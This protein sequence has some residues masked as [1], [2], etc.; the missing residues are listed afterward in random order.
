VGL[1][2][3]R[4]EDP[5]KFKRAELLIV[6]KRQKLSNAHGDRDKLCGFCVRGLAFTPDEK[7]LFVS[8]MKGGGISVFA[9]YTNGKHKYLGTVFGILP[10]PRDLDTS[11]DGKTLFISCNASGFVARVPVKNVLDTLKTDNHPTVERK[12]LDVKVAYVGLGARSLRLSPDER[13]LFVAVNQ[14]SEIVVVSTDDM[15][16]VSRIPVD[17]YPVGLDLSPDGTQLWVTSQGRDEE[18]GNSVGIF[19]VRYK[20]SEVVHASPSS[21][22]H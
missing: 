8:R 15:K 10:G 14:S 12:D 22:A 16:V 20:D 6:E 21:T 3:I 1:I 4:G 9:L 5:R 17:S 13:F 19:Q 7:H 11:R 2:D 18:G